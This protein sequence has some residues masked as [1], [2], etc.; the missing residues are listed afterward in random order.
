MQTTSRRQEKNL[1]NAQRSVERG[2][3]NIRKQ[4]ERIAQLQHARCDTTQAE[5][6]L[7]TFR[8]TQRLHE[9]NLMRIQSEIKEDDDGSEP[10]LGGL[11]TAREKT[12][13]ELGHA[14]GG[15]DERG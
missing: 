7:R 10:T 8:Q 13:L 4:L 12:P 5:T 9:E 3:I 14:R 2:R 6:V 15:K 11:P 1:A